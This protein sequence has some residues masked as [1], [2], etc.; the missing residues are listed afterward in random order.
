L[1]NKLFGGIRE[2]LRRRI[3]KKTSVIVAGIAGVGKSADQKVDWNSAQ[4]MKHGM[5]AGH[6]ID[7]DHIGTLANQLPKGL[8][9]R[10]TGGEAPFFGT[11]HRTDHRNVGV[12]F[13]H[14][15]ER[16]LDLVEINKS[17]QK[18]NV[19]RRI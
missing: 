5:R 18:T 7:T 9:D 2:I 11:N 1:P 14:C 16:D 8:N 12:E 6:A 3:V 4:D 17:L 10:Q 15:L 19:H 13:P